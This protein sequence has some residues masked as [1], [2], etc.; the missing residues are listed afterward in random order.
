MK[1]FWQLL[2]RYKRV[3]AGGIAIMLVSAGL[4]LYRLGTLV[5]GLSRAELSEGSAAYGWHGIAAH[6][7]FLPFEIV[8]SVVFKLFPTHGAFLTRLP[9]VFFSVIAVI[10]LTWLIKLWY[11]DRTAWFGFG[12]FAFSAWVLHIGR[13]ASHDVLYLLAIPLLLLVQ[14]GLQRYYTKASVWYSS[15]L[16]WGVLL[17][18]PGFFWLLVVH[19]YWQHKAIVRGWKLRGKLWQRLLYVLLGLVWVP[20]LIIDL[21]RP[22]Q[23]K[24]WLGLPQRFPSISHFAKQFVAVFVHAFVRGPQY[25]ALWLGKTPVLNAFVLVMCL[26][27]MYF[28]ARHY[29]AT[30]TKVVFSYVL[31]GVLLVS[32][33]GP[34]SFSLLVP[35]LY[36]FAV[37]GIA[38]L[39][40]DW[41]KVFPR[42]PVARGVGIGIISLC[43]LVSAGYSLR[44]YFVAWPHTAS[45]QALFRTTE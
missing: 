39:L 42:N 20:G 33:G 12:L 4:L 14:I 34:V 18:I 35:L 11:G 17:Y 15:M 27:G 19:F 45:T 41:L 36:I 28:Y 37:T 16:L 1:K 7:L 22:E 30:R 21:T 8:Q 24:L 3:I 40:V 10:T 6:P 29:K 38:F 44:S 26:I 2:H 23:F 9:N 25:P 32:I 5:P 13:Y 43:I 31:I